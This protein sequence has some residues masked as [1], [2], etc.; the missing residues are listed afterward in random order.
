ML[1]LRAPP[2][3]RNP[4]TTLENRTPVRFSGGG[5]EAK[6]QA[7]ADRTGVRIKG[8]C[9]LGGYYGINFCLYHPSSVDSEQD[10]GQE[11]PA[12]GEE[13]ARYR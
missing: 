6:E 1:V 5:A 7:C 12:T 9:K 11:L 13:T 4:C 3:H 8:G 2:R 10:R